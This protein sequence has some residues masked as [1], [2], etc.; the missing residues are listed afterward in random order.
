MFGLMVGLTIIKAFTLYLY[1][2]IESPYKFQ[3][4]TNQVL[5]IHT[6]F[7]QVGPIFAFLNCFFA[8]LA[9]LNIEPLL[10]NHWH[11]LY[12]L[13]ASGIGYLFYIAA[14]I[15]LIMSIFLSCLSEKHDR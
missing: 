1:Q 3:S 8:C 10:A 4:Y 13:S 14:I 15:L 11:Q 7:C 5:N 12:G 6:T 2:D 9:F